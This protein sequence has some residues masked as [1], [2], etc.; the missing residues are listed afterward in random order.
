MRFNMTKLFK[1][2]GLAAGIAVSTLALS[3]CSSNSV[4]T[5]DAGDEKPFRDEYANAVDA[6]D[7]AP[8]PAPVVVAQAQEMSVDALVHFDFDSAELRTEE[9]RKID[10]LIGQFDT[11]EV[12]RVDIALDGYADAIG[13]EEYNRALSENRAQS[14]RDYLSS[15]GVAVGEWSLDAY[16]ENNPLATN[17]TPAGRQMNRRVELLMEIEVLEVNTV[18]ARK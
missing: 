13:P 10:A 16:G 7:T 4:T 1:K 14:V 3:A 18:S 8:K 12:K 15:Q 2:S 17:E 11:Y 9:K 6:D 5:V